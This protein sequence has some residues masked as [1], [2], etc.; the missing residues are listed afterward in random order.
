MKSETSVETILAEGREQ[1]EV[2]IRLAARTTPPLDDLIR[3]TFKLGLYTFCKLAQF[4]S[5]RSVSGRLNKTLNEVL[6]YYGFQK[7]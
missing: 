7:T 2:M 4:S 1:L 3:F 6:Q 5:S